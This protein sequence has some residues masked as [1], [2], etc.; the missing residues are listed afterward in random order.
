MLLEKFSGHTPFHSVILQSGV[1]DALDN[2]EASDVNASLATW[3]MLAQG[4]NCGET[5]HQLD[6]LRKISADD[7]EK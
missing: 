2:S 3:E 5:I 6:C 7:I 1:N 4:L